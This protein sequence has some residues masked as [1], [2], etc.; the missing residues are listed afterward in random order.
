M[1]INENLKKDIFSGELIKITYSALVDSN[2][3]LENARNFL[4]E[5]RL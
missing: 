4:I 2:E 3:S 1:E 5:K